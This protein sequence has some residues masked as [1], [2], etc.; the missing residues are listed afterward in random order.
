ME[1]NTTLTVII[2]PEKIVG[3]SI[4]RYGFVNKERD[5]DFFVYLKVFIINAFDDMG[6][7]CDHPLIDYI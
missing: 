2:L 3:E 7:E 6:F 5:Q 1:N 4:F